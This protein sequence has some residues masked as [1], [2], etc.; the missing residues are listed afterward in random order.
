MEFDEI[1]DTAVTELT[2]LCIRRQR[3]EDAEMDA[4]VLRRVELSN[5][6]VKALEGMD[7]PTRQLFK[8]YLDVMEDIHSGQIER[9]YLQGAK[10]CVRIFKR[11]G[12][13]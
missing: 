4:L 9:L 1:M 12:V 6:A 10:D 11:L 3:E 2:E 13:L 8:D 5:Q 7:E